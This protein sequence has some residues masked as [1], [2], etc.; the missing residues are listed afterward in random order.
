MADKTAI[1]V[2]FELDSLT[3]YTDSF[4]A[5][6]WHVA[7]SNPADIRDYEA[8]NIAERIGREIIR[9]WLAQVPPELWSHQ[10][11]HAF[12]CELADARNERSLRGSR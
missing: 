10:G 6:L 8:G 9:R 7:Q 12:E 5:R 2:T 3:S 4:V 11:L 1:T